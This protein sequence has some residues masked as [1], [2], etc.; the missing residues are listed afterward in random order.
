MLLADPIKLFLG[1]A[2]VSFAQG[3]ETEE[4]RQDFSLEGVGFEAVGDNE[5]AALLHCDIRV[6]L[7]HLWSG[8][9]AWVTEGKR[10][11][12]EQ[13]E[14]SSFQLLEPLHCQLATGKMIEVEV[15]LG[16]GRPI[17]FSEF[18]EFLLQVVRFPQHEDAYLLD[19]FF[20]IAFDYRR[21]G[22]WLLHWGFLASDWHALVGKGRRGLARML[23]FQ[24]EINL[25]GR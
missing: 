17:E 19:E 24:G 16:V 12:H 6:L 9:D 1:V 13:R 5:I 4:E 8:F 25:D 23:I 11:I 2:E 15:L 20:V 21:W 22:R 7:Q 10:V 3:E 14:E 18:G